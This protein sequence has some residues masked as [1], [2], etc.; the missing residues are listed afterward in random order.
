MGIGGRIQTPLCKPLLPGHPEEEA[1]NSLPS[2]PSKYVLS[3]SS[4]SLPEELGELLQEAFGR[5]V[6]NLVLGAGMPILVLA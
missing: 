4:I 6:W 5:C 2:K 1:Q 3:C